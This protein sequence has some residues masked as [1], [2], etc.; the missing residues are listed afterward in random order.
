MAPHDQIAVTLN[1]DDDVRNM[2]NL[3]SCLKLNII[4]LIAFPKDD[5]SPVIARFQILQ[6]WFDFADEVCSDGGHELDVGTLTNSIDA[7]IHC[8]RGV[9]QKFK[10]AAEFRICLK[11]YVIASR[12][13]FRYM[14][15]ESVVCSKE[16]CEWKIYASKHKSDNSF[17]IRKCNL[18][19]SCG[20]DNLR[21]RGHPKADSSWVANVV[22]EKLRG[23][24]SYRP[25]AMLKDIERDYGV[26]LEYHK[27]WAGKEMAMHDIYGTDKGSYDKLRWYCHAVKETNPGSFVECEIDSMTNKF[28]RLFICFHACL[29]GFIS[30]CRPLLFLDGT[31][32]KNKYKGF[33]LGVVAKDAND[34]VF[35][36]AYAIVDAEN[37]SNWEWFCYQL[38]HVLASQYIMIFRSY[39][40][41]SDRH[42]GLIKAIQTV[43]PGIH[44]S[45]C[46]RHLVDNFVK[47]VL[48]RY[49]L[50]NKKHWSSGLKK[51][52]YTPSR[53]EF[54]QH[55]KSI[56]DSMPLAHEFL[57]SVPSENWANSMFVGERWGV[58][59]NNIV[60]SWNNWACVRVR[61]QHGRLFKKD[62]KMWWHF[63][64]IL[65]LFIELIDLLDHYVY[66]SHFLFAVLT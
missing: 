4:K 9:G 63:V 17:G 38:K 26:E 41:F 2:I 44:H 36:L 25:C 24:P 5:Q 45:Y 56:I 18:S 57:V 15:N 55:I 33:L 53:H 16:N 39:I 21:S 31:H 11:N 46:L 14:R 19:H 37:D 29:V 52:A 1:E 32:I 54:S 20:D 50:H 7:W 22:K 49:P 66:G 13:S 27:V 51:A 3:H 58:I 8:I 42:P 34:D 61:K 62:N 12:R 28:R 23:E 40:F 64:N 10:D 65:V 48:R 43:F 47:Q 59:N 30:G 35:T 60:E 6:S